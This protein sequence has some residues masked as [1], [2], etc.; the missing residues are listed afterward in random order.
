LRKGRGKGLS[1]I[2]LQYFGHGPRDYHVAPMPPHS[3][4]NWEFYAVL[5]GQCAPWL[6]EGEQPP[7]R[8]AT[9]WVFPPRHVHGWRGGKASCE[10]AA[11]HFG[12]VPRALREGVERCGRPWLEVPLDSEGVGMIRRL[13]ETLKPHYRRPRPGSGLREERAL[14]DLAILAVEAAP[15]LGEARVLVTEERRRVERALE[16]FQNQLGREATVQGAAEVCG[17]SPQHLR[18][19]FHH[20]LQDSPANVLRVVAL[21]HA[22][23]LMAQTDL[24]IERIAEACDFAGPSQL[25]RAFK[26]AFG[27]PPGLWRQNSR[28]EAPTA[29]GVSMEPIRKRHVLER[30]GKYLEILNGPDQGTTRSR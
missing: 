18:R 26:R 20:V 15:L 17:V 4:A 6:P 13:I 10:V 9:M 14:L 3:R 23:A 30:L 2:V 5:A 24:T 27:V 25:S 1:G 29:G 19:L 28:L 21:D 11:L 8:R 16:Y 22:V 12:A 7:L